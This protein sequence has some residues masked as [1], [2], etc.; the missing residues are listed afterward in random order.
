MEIEEIKM[1]GKHRKRNQYVEVGEHPGMNAKHP[2]LGLKMSVNT[3][4]YFS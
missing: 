4:G 2:Q 1:A 3:D